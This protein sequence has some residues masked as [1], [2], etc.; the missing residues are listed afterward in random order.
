MPVDPC[1][2]DAH[3]P[4]PGSTRWRRLSPARRSRSRPSC[5]PALSAAALGEEVAEDYAATGLSLRRHPLAL[6]RGAFAAADAV[7]ASRLAALDGGAR[8]GVAGLVL[9]RQRPGTASG[10]TFVTLED[11]TGVAN[12]VVWSGV[13]E[14]Y[15]REVMA[16][17]PL[18]ASGRLQREGRVVHVVARRL[19]DHLRA[20]W[21]AA[22]PA[23]LGRTGQAALPLSGFPLRAATLRRP[24]APR[25]QAGTMSN[26]A[27][28]MPS[29]ATS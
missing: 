16:A 7:P 10:V 11:E 2:L 13:F 26:A 20:R 12:L 19:E 4:P 29:A 6:L 22:P 8:V 9:V 27:V 24:P 17:R 21:R 3:L 18:L 23:R 1:A 25:R 15:R 28:S 5:A 14:R